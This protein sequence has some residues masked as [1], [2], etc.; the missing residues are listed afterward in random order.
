MV[1]YKFKFLTDLTGQD[2]PEED[3]GNLSTIVMHIQEGW[4]LHAEIETGIL[5][6]AQM[7]LK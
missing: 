6:M 1:Y 3:R 7:W 5:T 4:S 2:Y